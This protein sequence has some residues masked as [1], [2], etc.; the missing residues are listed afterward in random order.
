[1][2]FE[3]MRKHIFWITPNANVG[4]FKKTN[5]IDNVD[6]IYKFGKETFKSIYMAYLRLILAGK[7]GPLEKLRSRGEVEHHKNAL[8]NIYHS[9]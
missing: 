5:T 9:M 3:R 4:I 8:L 2:T 6:M 7:F 1:M